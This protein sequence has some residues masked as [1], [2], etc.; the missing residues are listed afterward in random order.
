MIA[1]FSDTLTHGSA[2]PSMRFARQ[3]AEAAVTLGRYGKNMVPSSKLDSMRY[4]T[5]SSHRNM[6]Q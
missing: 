4:Y 3:M 6:K 2:E 5:V 1:Q